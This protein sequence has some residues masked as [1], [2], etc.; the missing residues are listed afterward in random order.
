MDA[1][2]RFEW[3][4]AVFCQ[5]E[6]ARIGQCLSS[7]RQAVGT[8]RSLVTLIANGTSDDS[9]AVAIA[10]A[11]ECGLPLAVYSIKAGDKSN[12]INRFYYH[13][14]VPART[15]FSV[16]GY[17][18]IGPRSLTGLDDC[19]GANAHA[20]AATGVC[21]NGRTMHLATKETLERGGRL[22]GQLHAFRPEFIERMVSRNIRLPLGIYW[23]DGLLGSMAAH[24]L[25]AMGEEWDNARIVGVADATYEIPTLSAFRFN[26]LKRQLKRRVRQ[27][28]GRL[29]NRAIK[30][31][32]YERGYEGLPE[33]ADDM[34][35]QHIGAH[36]VPK[37]SLL[38]RPFMARALRETKGAKPFDAASLAPVLHGS[39]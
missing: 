25:D 14:R 6:A 8:R 38:E 9:V 12:A 3:N 10:A 35:R 33:D 5:N 20:M 18:T 21:I 30:T 11:K 19:L 15:Y 22:H 16:D 2:A 31:I 26:D 28:R 39:L 34:V 23:G 37:V 36:G 32:I 24:N 4:I 17:V 27:M 7:I 1:S 13:L 29:Q